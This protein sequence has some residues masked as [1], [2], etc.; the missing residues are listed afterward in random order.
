MIEATLK[1]LDLS[2][3]SQGGSTGENWFGQGTTIT[4]VSPVDG[5]KIGTVSTITVEEYEHTVNQADRAFLAFRKIP[6]PKRWEMVRQ[7]GDALR[8]KKEALGELVSYEMGK[9]LQ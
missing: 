7:L 8:E 2:P 4:S 5:K 3:S 9:S 6:A 1:K